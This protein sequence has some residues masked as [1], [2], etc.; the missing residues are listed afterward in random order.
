[1]SQFDPI[2]T[3]KSGYA[4]P[5]DGP[6]RCGHCEHYSDGKCNHP[7]VES[8]KQVPKAADGKGIVEADGCCNYFRT[9]GFRSGML[10]SLL[11][12]PKV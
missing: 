9:R 2:G 6:F 3:R 8:D 4:P 1:M 12:K 10:I 7:D 11:K 5:R